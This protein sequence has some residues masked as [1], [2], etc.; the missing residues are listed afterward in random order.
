MSS[1]RYDRRVELSDEAHHHEQALAGLRELIAAGRRYEAFAR[2][3]PERAA[4]QIAELNV[5]GVQEEA[6]DLGWIPKILRA[7]IAREAS[8]VVLDLCCIPGDPDH[9]PA[10][11]NI[12][13]PAAIA[14]CCVVA[15]AYGASPEIPSH[16]LRGNLGI[17]GRLLH[18][19]Q[20]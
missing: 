5:P 18:R 4:A 15:Q 1:V 8:M 7:K 17:L 11:M 14:A 20:G 9:D 13:M 6:W 19:R 2:E 3:N 10:L 16:P 12:L